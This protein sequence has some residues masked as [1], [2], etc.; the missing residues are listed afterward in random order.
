MDNIKK[1][2]LEEAKISFQQ[3]KNFATEAVKKEFENELNIKV[4]KILN[5]SLKSVEVDDE[6]NITVTTDEKII[7][8]NNDGEVENVESVEGVESIDGNLGGED[9]EEIEIEKNIDEMMYNEEEQLQQAPAA[10]GMPAQDAAAPADAS[11]PADAPTEEVPAQDAEVPQEVTNLA[12]A[13]FDAIKSVTG[14]EEQGD[15]QG[16]DY[17][18]DEAADTATPAPEQA[19]AAAPAAP[20]QEDALFEFNMEEMKNENKEKIEFE[21]VPEDDELFEFTLEEEEE[22]EEVGGEELEEMHGVGHNFKHDNKLGILPNEGANYRKEYDLKESTNKI[23]A[24][25]ESKIDELLKENKRLNESNKEFGEVIKNYRSSF[26]DLR[27][28]FDEMQTFNAKLAYANK[29]FASGGLSTAEKAMIA[30]NFDKTQTR[31]EAKKLYDKILEENKIFIN[32]DNVSKITS[33]ATNT[34]KA[35]ETIFE[36]DEMKRRKV[37][38]GI[39]K[40]ENY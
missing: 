36:S 34:I 20:V 3:I 10:D 26:T 7:A 2:P 28:Q 40:N 22:E 21:D 9:E 4:E 17:I 39:G 14:G 24:Q 1:T 18:D 27:K 6:N 16:V 32:K 23:K 33:P 31:E 35:K 15:D 38:A 12:K 11:A 13:F 19:P 30:E 8:L 5:E 25:Y 29:I 37:L